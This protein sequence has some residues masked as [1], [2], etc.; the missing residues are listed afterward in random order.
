VCAIKE[1]GLTVKHKP[2]SMKYV[3]LYP[4]HY[5]RLEIAGGAN[6]CLLNSKQKGL[7]VD[8]IKTCRIV[9]WDQIGSGTLECF[10]SGVP[11]IVY[12]K[13]M[14]SRESPWAKELIANLEHC[15]VVHTD[16]VELALETKKYLTDPEGWMADKGRKEAIQAFC[17]KYALTDP[18]WYIK[19]RVQLLQW[20]SGSRLFKSR[21]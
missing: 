2:Y 6:Y 13:R 12:W 9:L 17:Q 15:G 3:D 4:E 5:R 21:D 20:S 11:T 18:R 7:S 14:Y 8:L 10:T 16:A 19:W 1:I